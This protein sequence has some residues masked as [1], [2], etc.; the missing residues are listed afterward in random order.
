[1]SQQ[2]K[3]NHRHIDTSKNKKRKLKFKLN[4]M[5]RYKDI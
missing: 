4:K 1:M 3:T 2:N 5:Y